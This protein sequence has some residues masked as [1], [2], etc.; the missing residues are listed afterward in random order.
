MLIPVMLVLSIV[1]IA[2]APFS[3]VGLGG[4]STLDTVRSTV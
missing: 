4:I 3:K 1:Q 2:L